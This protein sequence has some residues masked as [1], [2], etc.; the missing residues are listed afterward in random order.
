MS[1]P[2]GGSG[3]AGGSIIASNLTSTNPTNSAEAAGGFGGEGGGGFGTTTWVIAEV[4]AARLRSN[5]TAKAAS[6]TPNASGTC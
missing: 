2:N 5:A 1:S 6:M 3:T 4:L